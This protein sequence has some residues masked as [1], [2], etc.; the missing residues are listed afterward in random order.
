MLSTAKGAC[1]ALFTPRPFGPL[2]DMAIQQQCR[3][4][5]LHDA[6]AKRA[7]ILAAVLND[8]Q[9]YPT[10]AVFEDVH[11][12]NEA[13]LD[14]LR[15]LGRRIERTQALAASILTQNIEVFNTIAILNEL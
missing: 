8:L 1:D 3:L 12:A 6:D 11:W 10:I 4:L 13:T 5:A 2:H 9:Q 14:P 7:S 15:F